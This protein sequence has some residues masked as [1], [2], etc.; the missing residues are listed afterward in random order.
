MQMLKC[1]RRTV[2]SRSTKGNASGGGELLVPERKTSLASWEGGSIG[3]DGDFPGQQ[4]RLR[5]RQRRPE[6]G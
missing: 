6:F 5:G 1:A 4:L 2:S 3:G